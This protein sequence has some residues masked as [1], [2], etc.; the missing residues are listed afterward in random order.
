VN[1]PP[2]EPEPHHEGIDWIR[3][4]DGDLRHPLQHRCSESAMK[5]WHEADELGFDK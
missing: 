4:E 5:F 1:E 3:T 2:P